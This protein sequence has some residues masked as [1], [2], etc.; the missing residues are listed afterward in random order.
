[1]YQEQQDKKKKEREAKRGFKKIS[2]K[3][4]TPATT[5]VTPE[6]APVE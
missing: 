1:M 3:G 5:A 2:K 4:A 6:N